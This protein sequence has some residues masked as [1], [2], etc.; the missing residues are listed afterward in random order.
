M[1]FYLAALQQIS[2]S[3]LEAAELEGASI[4]QRFGG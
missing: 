2:P 4:W 1:I 3:L